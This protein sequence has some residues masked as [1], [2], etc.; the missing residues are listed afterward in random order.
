MIEIEKRNLIL[1]GNLTNQIN[2]PVKFLIPCQRGFNEKQWQ[3]LFTA[4]LNEI[5][6]NCSHAL[7]QLVSKL[8][9]RHIRP[10]ITQ[11]VL[12]VI[13]AFGRM[14][15]VTSKKMKIVI[16]Q[17]TLLKTGMVQDNRQQN[18][19]FFSDGICLQY[20]PDLL[21]RKRNRIKREVRHVGTL[22]CADQRASKIRRHKDVKN[23]QFGMLMLHRVL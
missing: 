18:L 11:G 8:R 15:T 6:Q 23:N 2:L 3:P 4:E 22:F 17:K 16:A 21:R 20:A 7:R 14:R 19:T 5:D 9:I 12:C 1:R 10:F 13:I